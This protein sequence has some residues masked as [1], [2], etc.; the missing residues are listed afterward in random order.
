MSELPEKHNPPTSRDTYR[1]WI[2][3]T[4]KEVYALYIIKESTTTTPVD[5]YKL[6]KK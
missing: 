4:L 2:S 6:V 5:F 1:Y 3:Y